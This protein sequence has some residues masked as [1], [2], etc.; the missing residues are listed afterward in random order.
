MTRWAAHAIGQSAEQ[1]LA[2]IR[3][4]G[5]VAVIATPRAQV[6]CRLQRD[7]ASIGGDPSLA[8]FDN[9]PLTGDKG[10]ITQIYVRGKGA[11]ELDEGMFM[12]AG[13]PLI[14]FIETADHQP[15]RLLV[16][17]RA[18][19][20]LVTL[21]DVQKLPVYG[22]LFGLLIAAEM[23]LVEWIRNTCTTQPDAWLQYLRLD[24][25]DDIEGHWK[26][27]LKYNVAIDRLS[28]AS[29]GQELQAAHRLGLFKREDDRWHQFKS[30]QKLRNQVGHGME[31]ASTPAL[32]LQL[33]QRVRE[34]QALATWL[35]AKIDDCKT[36]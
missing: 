35:E 9:V 24:E 27:A 4:Q 36:P 20:G 23:L 31:F 13:A 15:F 29:L 16:D 32:A 11:V 25:R 6:Q 18:V 33:P 7:S 14:D 21:S 19:T 28:C 22:L 17:G 2:A 12:S 3:A 34:A 8:D 26:K 5:P 1:Y 30:L 10:Q